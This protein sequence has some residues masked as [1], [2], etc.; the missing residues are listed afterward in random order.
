MEEDVEHFLKS[1][2]PAYFEHVVAALADPVILDDTPIDIGARAGVAVAPLHATAYDELL[3]SADIA[4]YAAKA[5]GDEVA[6]Y[7]HALSARCV[8]AHY[9]LGLG[10]AP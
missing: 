6:V 5:A 3:K 4:M 10:N 2:D 8:L 9:N 7:D 1:I